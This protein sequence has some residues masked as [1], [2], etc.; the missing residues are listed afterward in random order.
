MSTPSTLAG[1]NV[2]ATQAAN[3]VPI[4]LPGREY[5]FR[6]SSDL[7]L[8][9]KLSTGQILPVG[10][11]PALDVKVKVTTNDS[12]P[13]FLQPKLVAGSNMGIVLNNPGGNE[14]L[15]LNS[16][17][18][19]NTSSNVGTG[20]GLA[21]A[22]VGV[23]LPFKSLKAGTNI[24]LTPSATEILIDAAGGGGR[25]ALGAG[26]N[27][28]QQIGTSSLATGSG[29]LATGID[30][31]ATRP[32]EYAQ[33]DNHNVGVQSGV[34]QFTRTVYTAEASG[35][36]SVT[37]TNSAGNAYVLQNLLTCAVAFKIT[38]VGTRTGPGPDGSVGAYFYEGAIQR[39]AAVTSFV[40]VPVLTNQFRVG[41]AV[42]VPWPVALVANS[43]TN[44][45]EVQCG[46][47]INQTVY[48]VATLEATELNL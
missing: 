31:R 28:A 48:W 5:I 25:F 10:T 40:Q 11:P 6:D 34:R 35:L 44:A 4:P 2:I 23:N 39:F 33:S 27:S 3:T 37:L 15:T 46:A 22:K 17:G 47:F 18:E 38:I 19:A 42:N 30:S 32:S 9:T 8:Y 26:A 7:L 29:S 45:L 12:T 13:N 20:A 16:T 21:N 36:G 41:E 24:T 43:A 14:T 1:L